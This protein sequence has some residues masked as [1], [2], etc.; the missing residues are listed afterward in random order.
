ML[1]KQ[2]NKTKQK[3]KPKTKQNKKPTSTEY[4]RYSLQNSELK[5][6]NKLKCQNEIASVPLGKQ[7]KAITRGKGRMDLGEK[8]DREGAQ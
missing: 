2:T 1:A 8:V 7:K 4:P 6:V 3:A 5:K